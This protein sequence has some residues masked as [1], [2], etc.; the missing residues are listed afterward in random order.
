MLA[1]IYSYTK[2]LPE[3]EYRLRVKAG[4]TGYAQIMGKYNTSPKDKLILD[5]MYI[6]SYSFWKDLQLLFQTIMVLLRS[7]D[8]TEGF[9]KEKDTEKESEQTKK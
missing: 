8:S 6:E 2:A 3:F 4:L 1:N 5:L 9:H 7:E